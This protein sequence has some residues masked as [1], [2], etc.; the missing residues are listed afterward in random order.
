[1][2]REERNGLLIGV[3]VVLSHDE[4]WNEYKVNPSESE[5]GKEVCYLCQVLPQSNELVRVSHSLEF[6]LPFHCIDKF[7]IIPMSTCPISDKLVHPLEPVT[8]KMCHSLFS[9]GCRRA[10]DY[11]GAGKVSASGVN[12]EF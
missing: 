8:K 10:E 11:H 7:V 5:Y 6:E 12:F 1:M 3:G 9:I 2:K 4:V